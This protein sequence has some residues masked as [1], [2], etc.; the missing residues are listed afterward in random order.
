MKL[1]FF[2][3]FWNQGLEFEAQERTWNAGTSD[4]EWGGDN[5]GDA[6][7]VW[8][9]SRFGEKPGGKQSTRLHKNKT[10]MKENK[11]DS[12]MTHIRTR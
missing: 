2:L 3:F 9:E 8:R 1:T 4:E 10:Q 5:E 12:T 6:V 11:N 7:Q